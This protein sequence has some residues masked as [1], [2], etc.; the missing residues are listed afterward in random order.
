MRHL[1]L[2]AALALTACADTGVMQ[3]GPNRYRITTE[4]GWTV[5]TAETSAIREAQAHCATLGRTADVQVVASRPYS[6]YRHYAGASVEFVC[7]TP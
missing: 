3:V 7:L 4:S 6:P 5:G 2:L 1:P